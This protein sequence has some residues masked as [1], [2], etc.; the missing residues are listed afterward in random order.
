MGCM[1]LFTLPVVFFS[2]GF[3]WT[4][5]ITPESLVTSTW[6]IDP[7]LTLTSPNING[8]ITSVFVNG[9]TDGSIYYLTNTITTS[10]ITNK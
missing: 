9:G 8:N 5:E 6:A 7:S 4:K 1:K 3:D 2:Y 10:T